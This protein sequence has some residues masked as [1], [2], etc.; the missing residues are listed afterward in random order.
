M[1]AH[2]IGVYGEKG[3]DGAD[4]MG[5]TNYGH[6]SSSL[7]TLPALSMVTMG[8]KSWLSKVSTANPPMGTVMSGGKRV[9]TKDA[10][11]QSVY[12]LSGLV[13][14]TE[15]ELVTESGRVFTLVPTVGSVVQTKLGFL[16][17]SAFLVNVNQTVGS[18]SMP[19]S[20]GWVV[21]RAMDYNGAMVQV[22]SAS[23]TS[24][25]SITAY[26]SYTQ[27][28]VRLYSSYSNAR[29]WQGD[30]IAEATIPVVSDGVDGK[31]GKDGRAGSEPRPRGQW[32]SGNTYVYNEKFRDIVVYNGHIYRVRS[33]GASV[34]AAPT[35]SDSDTNW[36]G[37][38]EMKF[39]ATDLLLAQDVYTDKLTVTKVNAKSA[40]GKTTC[41]IDGETGKLKAKKAEFDGVTSNN[42]TATNMTVEGMTATNANVE[43]VMTVKTLRRKLL[44]DNDIVLNGSAYIR[45]F[46]SLSL[47]ELDYGDCVEVKVMLT[48][49]TK[50][51]VHNEVKCANSN[52]VLYKGAWFMNAVYGKADLSCD[53]EIVG[54]RYNQ[55]EDSSDKTYWR[56]SPIY[57][58]DDSSIT[59]T[60]LT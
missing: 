21:A 52:V 29:N 14:T 43:G 19:Y 59:I 12:V 26:G 36:E 13:N 58:G 54:Y 50:M 23:Q 39:V 30:F 56:I 35:G 38:D 45:S 11:G 49:A 48:A 32:V 33:Y 44:S 41:T 2:V 22:V 7:G 18:V 37:A 20:K 60:S 1:P 15:W 27:Y 34:T 55:G 31:D 3:A 46:A 16:S 40:D 9:K 6:W 24:Q 53:V 17:P 10:S 4:G 25:I 47:P 28:V 57:G 5:I 42:M 8:G 51:I